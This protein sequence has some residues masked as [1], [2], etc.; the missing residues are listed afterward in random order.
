M[1][2][3]PDIIFIPENSSV[4][5]KRRK[6]KGST[7]HYLPDQYGVEPLEDLSWG[8]LFLK[9]MNHQLLPTISFPD[10]PTNPCSTGVAFPYIPL[11]AEGDLMSPSQFLF[12]PLDS[13]EWEVTKRIKRQMINYLRC[14]GSQMFK[15]ALLNSNTL[16]WWVYLVH[17]TWLGTLWTSTSS[18]WNHGGTY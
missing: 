10:P 4:R 15:I 11:K 7:Q 3:L 8:S 12:Q 9:E 14:L 13:Q 2:E 17:Y 18:R 6:I 1:W 5:P 16:I